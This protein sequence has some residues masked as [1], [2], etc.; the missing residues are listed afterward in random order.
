MCRSVCYLPAF[1][2]PNTMLIKNTRTFLRGGSIK[3]IKNRSGNERGKINE[4]VCFEKKFNYALSPGSFEPRAM[5]I[6]RRTCLTMRESFTANF[7]SN[8]CSQF[9][10]TVTFANATRFSLTANFRFCGSFSEQRRV[11]IDFVLNFHEH[12]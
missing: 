1:S 11:L 8:S 10:Q 6:F 12:K 2:F 4:A 3:H 5:T 9:N 7:I